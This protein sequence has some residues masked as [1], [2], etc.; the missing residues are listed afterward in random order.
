MLLIV[1]KIYCNLCIFNI[2]IVFGLNVI[3]YLA[4]LSLSE[5][6]FDWVELINFAVCVHIGENKK[7]FNIFDLTTKKI[8][9]KCEIFRTFIISLI[10]RNNH[11]IIFAAAVY[12]L[13][14][15]T[16]R[17]FFKFSNEVVQF[18]RNVLGPYRV[19]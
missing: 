18:F 7:M 14:L 9:W 15:E 1:M 10:W 8:Y 2:F 17:F 3:Q 11:S 16:K 5:Y 13:N 19:G 4:F 12:V 6:I